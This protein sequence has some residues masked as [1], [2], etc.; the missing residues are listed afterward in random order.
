MD[1]R[2][3]ELGADCSEVCY[4]LLMM[5]WCKRERNGHEVI[6]DVLKNVQ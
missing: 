1:N 6:T 4:T 3:G 2:E 5:F